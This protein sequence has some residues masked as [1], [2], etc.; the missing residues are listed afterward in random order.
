MS[1]FEI[2]QK[3]DNEWNLHVLFTIGGTQIRARYVGKTKSGVVVKALTGL[4]N[5]RDEIANIRIRLLTEYD[6]N[7]KKP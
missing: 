6:K 4:G 1:S 7:P 5:M 2:T 3:S